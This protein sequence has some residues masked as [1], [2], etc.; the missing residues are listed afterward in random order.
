MS[1]ATP[2]PPDSEAEL[3]ECLAHDRARLRAQRRRL[4]RHPAPQALA[5]WRAAVAEAEARAAQRAAALPQPRF[6][7]ALPVNQHR[8]RIARA[9]AAHQVVVLCGETGSGK[10][11]QLP[12]ICL[13]LGRGARGL[14]GHTQPR[15][16]AARSVAARLSEE[17][18]SPLGQA[19][20]YK[21]R[22]HDRVSADSYVKVMTDGILLAEIQSDAE[23][24]Q[25]DT[26]IIDEAHERSLNIDFLLGYLKRLLPRRPDLKVIITSA[27]LD[28]ER[29]ARHFDAPVVSVEGR[30][31]PV[32]VRY[33]PSQSE[34]GEA[35]LSAGIVAAVDEL[36][37][38]PAGDVLVFLPG[39]REI[40]EAAEALRKHHPPHTEILPL[41]A[42]LSAAEQ[43]R[44]FQAHGG[45]RIVLATN[46]AETSLTVPGIR[47]VVDTGLARISRYSYRSKMQRLPIEPVSRASADQR[48]GR[49]GR[50]APGVCIRLY[51]E[52]DYLARAEYTPPEIQRT[53]LAAVILRMA[54]LRLGDVARFPFVDPP[55]PRA[56]NDGYRLLQE[57][58][59]VDAK[60]RLT[61]LGRRL[62]RFPVDPRLARMV[63]AAQ[64]EDCVREVLVIAAALS[65]QDPRER[66]VAAQQQADEAHKQW[67][68]P[69]SDFLA[70]VSLW[71][72]WQEAQRHLS[73]RKLRQWCRER[74]LS[75]VRLREW[76]DIHSQ[77]KTVALEGGA[78]LSETPAEYAPLHRALLAGLLGHVGHKHED[79]Y[80]GARGVQFQP[81]PSSGLFKKGP[82]WLMAGELVETTRVYAR[83]NA[84]VEPAWV[85]QVGAHLVRRHHF[86]PHWERKAGHVVAYEQ[87]TLWGLVLTARRRVNYAPLDPAHAREIFIRDALVAGDLATRAPFYAHN[88]A[89]IAE[90]ESLESKTRRRD[91]LVDEAVLYA[92]YDARIPAEVNSAAGFEVWRKRAEREA[93]RLL[94][95]T[96]E[97]LMQHGAEGAAAF[98]DELALG[99]LVLRL[100]YRFEPGHPEDGVTV[101]VPLAALGQLEAGAFEWLV[102]GL[103]EEK[104]V[105]LI[106]SLPKGLRRHFVPA[107]DFA[108]AAVQ[109]MPPRVA[110]LREALAAQ[111]RR[112]TGVVIDP[113]AFDEAGLPAH[114]RMH[115][116]VLGTDGKVLDQDRDLDAL[117]ARLAARAGAQFSAAVHPEWEREAVEAWDVGELP[118]S[119][120]FE[121][122]GL[123]LRGYPALVAEGERVALRLLDDPAKAAAAHREGVRALGA[124]ALNRELRYLRKNLPGLDRLC[125]HYAAV[126]RCQ[127][128]T[129]D[130]VSAALARALALDEAPPPRTPADFE[131][132]CAAAQQ[133]LVGQGNELAAAV[134]EALAE[135]HGVRKRLKGG[136]PPAWLEAAGDMRAQLGALV[137][138][139]FVARTPWTWLQH[140]PRYLRALARRLDKL[141]RDPQRDRAPRLE[142]ARLLES[143]RQRRGEPNP[144]DALR[145]QLEE[146]RVS[147]FAQELGTAQPV[148]VPRLARD[149]QG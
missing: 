110:P 90:I 134:G 13:T 120:A 30:G 75:Y 123:A 50:V 127:D 60:R 77:L 67:A 138:P 148:S 3:N 129:E 41:Y 46:V 24:A 17:L 22:F 108:R 53:N 144:R 81:H 61:P 72:A 92:F 52:A 43:A 146:L 97:D 103:L 19:V 102:P 11:T 136:L 119:V 91:I 85:E 142:L 6:D 94:F 34:E 28:P 59:A 109:A 40:R 54:D 107:P 63:L 39:E 10:T 5:E 23:L 37:G 12:K 87:V 9:V 126:G 16:I 98:P 25:Y 65:V 115:F 8:E 48:K 86:E 147:L 7:E 84:K 140:Y 69:D 33:R 104:V 137:Y 44:I 32:E 118:D 62:A 56:V 58:G 145:W 4:G 125:L 15:R 112:M 47:Y 79:A 49:C 93:P 18:Q 80:R 64:A 55:E 36:A 76:Q 106:K 38:E 14:I 135:Y 27:T 99:P 128:L 133:N 78:R 143:Y 121:R 26:L 100:R 20:G 111:L 71:R 113:A 21:V 29:F 105:A 1:P 45:R 130:L 101:E 88:R 114:L 57:L 124:R 51:D 149:L 141:E 2:R 132:R 82:R 74:F 68:H 116:R 95:L 139:G 31:Y 42:R 122:G 73:Q 83:I 131:A 70:Y 96:R 117:K 66:P 35:D 89:L